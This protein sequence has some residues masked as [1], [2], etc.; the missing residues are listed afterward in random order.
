MHPLSSEVHFKDADSN[1]QNSKMTVSSVFEILGFATITRD[2]CPEGFGVGER[3]EEWSMAMFRIRIIVLGWGTD[4][5]S[6]VE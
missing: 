2:V 1:K 3:S 5:D 6:N 4:A